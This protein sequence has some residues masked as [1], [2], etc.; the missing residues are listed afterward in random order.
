MVSTQA[1]RHAVGR[2][3]W[4]SVL[5]LPRSIIAPIPLVIFEGG[6]GWEESRKKKFPKKKNFRSFLSHK[7]PV[8][9]P[10]TLGPV[11]IMNGS[12]AEL[13]YSRSR[14]APGRHGTFHLFGNLLWEAKHLSPSLAPE[15]N[16]YYQTELDSSP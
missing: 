4:K 6:P 16:F 11:R 8:C 12:S 10:T 9:W 2:D 1:K 3:F 13:A 15:P 14:L 5:N 7:S